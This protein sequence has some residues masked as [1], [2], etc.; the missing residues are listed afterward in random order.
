M[1]MSGLAMVGL[2]LRPPSRVLRTVSRVS[3]L[4]FVIYPFNTLFLCLYGH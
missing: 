2:V 4:L 1:M 3:L